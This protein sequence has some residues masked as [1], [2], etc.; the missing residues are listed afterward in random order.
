ME[1][2]LVICHTEACAEGAVLRCEE[3]AEARAHLLTLAQ[4]SLLLLHRIE[5]PARR[6]RRRLYRYVLRRACTPRF[7]MSCECL[8]CRVHS[9]TMLLPQAPCSVPRSGA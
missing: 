7:L 6:M 8:I 1:G 5:L 4:L 2:V 9:T 3:R